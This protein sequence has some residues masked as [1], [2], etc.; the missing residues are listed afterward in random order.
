MKNRINTILERRSV[1]VP[2]NAVIFLT[3]IFIVSYLWRQSAPNL[4]GLG[5]LT[6]CWVAASGLTW[7]ITSFAKGVVRLALAILLLGILTFIITSQHR[8]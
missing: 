6:L 8:M 2:L 4:T 1:G 7:M 3:N 5:R